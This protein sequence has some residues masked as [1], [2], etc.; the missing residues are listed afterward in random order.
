MK[1][2]ILRV[3]EESFNI[4]EDGR[5]FNPSPQKWA[6][7][8][9]KQ[10]INSGQTK[11]RIDLNEAEGFF[12]HTIRELTG[13][14][15]P[16]EMELIQRGDKTIAVNVIPALRTLSLKIDDYGNVTHKQA[17]LDTEP[18]KD[19]LALYEN[20]MGGFSWAFSGGDSIGGRIA[21][22][23]SGFDYVKQPNFIPKHRQ[24]LL[25]SSMQ[26]DDQL[27]LSSMQQRGIEDE[28]AQSILSTFNSSVANDGDIID[29]LLLSQLTEEKKEREEIL[30]SSIDNSLFFISESQKQALLRCSKDDTEELNQ[31]FSSMANTDT[32][33]LP[34]MNNQITVPGNFEK[35]DTKFMP[36]FSADRMEL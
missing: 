31:L 27:L 25:L 29:Q 5:K 11:E 2:E 7:Q 30:L 33:H 14:I 8:A 4:F 28:R 20:D 23:F 10:V 3:V 34:V 12:G 26:N 24:K 35:D 22:M 13:K 6:L 17:F 19:A 21:K 9:L 36:R 32:S 15:N 1:K 18:G 16:S